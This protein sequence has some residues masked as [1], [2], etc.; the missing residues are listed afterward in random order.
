MAS[1]PPAPHQYVLP[2]ILEPQKLLGQQSQDGAAH[3]QDQGVVQQDAVP[4][5]DAPAGSASD[6][7]VDATTLLQAVSGVYHQVNSDRLHGEW[8]QGWASDGSYWEKDA[9]KPGQ[10]WVYRQGE[11][12]SRWR[13]Q[14]VTG[15]MF[16]FYFHGNVFMFSLPVEHT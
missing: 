1:S 3:V 9:E 5:G 12:W 13:D 10:W 7:S 8:Q 11:S 15:A 16:Q 6:Q 4:Q 2:K 14:T